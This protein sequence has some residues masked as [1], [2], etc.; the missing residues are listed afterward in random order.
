MKIQLS[1]HF[2]YGKLLRF[3]VSSIVMMIVTSMYSIVD[4][5]FVSN[6]VGDLAFSAVN[7][8][9]PVTMIVGAVGFMLGTGGS[10]VVAKTLGEGKDELANRYFSMLIAVVAVSAVV[11]S[12]VCIL[13][14]EPILRISGAS[15]LLMDDCICYGRIMLGGSLLFML[16]VAFQSFLVVAEK[17]QLGLAVSVA[18]GVTNM[19]FDYVLIRIAGMG[20]AGAAWA[21]VLGYVVAGGIPLFYFLFSKK[22]RIRLVKPRFYGN[23]LLAAC[24]NGS[25]E[26]MNNIATSVVSILFNVQLMKLLGEKGVAA[27]GVMMYVDFVFASTFL[28]FSMGSAPVVSYHYGAGNHDELKSLFRKCMTIIGAFSAVMVVAS[29]LLCAPLSAI[30]VGYDKELFEMTV[31]GFRMF[32][33]NYVVCGVNIFASAFFTAL[34]NGKISALLAFLRSFLFRGGMVLLLP[35]VAGVDGIWL[36]VAAAEFFAAIFSVAFFVKKRNEYHYA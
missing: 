35:L 25:S 21:T 32:A 18:A 28:G 13:F 34:C 5:L 30:F 33:L 17:P 2:T 7:I 19:V 6:L 10:A 27:F 22:S 1:N 24:T 36:S 14:L 12:A 26:M 15:D 23:V 31:H 4:G 16:Q 9:F 20:I 29:Q 3:T 11:L 8:V